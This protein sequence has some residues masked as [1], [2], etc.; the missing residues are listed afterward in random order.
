MKHF[1]FLLLWPILCQATEYQ[2]TFNVLLDG[3]N[4]TLKYK[5]DA[6]NKNEAFKEAGVFCG[7]FFGIGKKDLTE[8]QVDAIVNA[9]TNP[10]VLIMSMR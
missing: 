3:K 4:N 6:K 9:C 1:F 2:F 7:D 10:Q 5:I 8:T